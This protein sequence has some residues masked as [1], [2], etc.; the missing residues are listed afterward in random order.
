ML[1]PVGNVLIAV[2]V[3]LCCCLAF[4]TGGNSLFL[5]AE[6]IVKTVLKCLFVG[7]GSLP[8]FITACQIAVILSRGIQENIVCNIAS[9]AL[10][11]VNAV[12]AYVVENI[13]LYNNT[14]GII[15]HI[16][17]KVEVCSI[18]IA[19]I[20]NIVIGNYVTQP[21]PVTSRINGCHIVCIITGIYNLVSCNCH[22]VTHKLNNHMGCIVNVV[23]LCCVSYALK[24]N[25][26]CI[27][28]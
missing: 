28:C 24:V 4:I 13:V 27:G 16:N 9:V 12:T 22:I 7:Q 5:C 10:V 11:K 19:N 21:R 14:G 25:C 6:H 18:G 15:I 26:G 23:V 2:P 3:A 17:T 8:A 20:L 1:N